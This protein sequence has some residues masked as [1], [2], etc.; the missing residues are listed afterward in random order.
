M[1][2]T[3]TKVDKRVLSE[4]SSPVSYMGAVWAT[5]T[6]GIRQVEETLG[7]Y[8]VSFR[9]GLKNTPPETPWPSTYAGIPDSWHHF[10]TRPKENGRVASSTDFRP[11]PN[12]SRTGTSE[13]EFDGQNNKGNLPAGASVDTL[14]L[15]H[16]LFWC[17]HS[18]WGRLVI[19]QPNSWYRVLVFFGEIF[20]LERSGVEMRSQSLHAAHVHG[21]SQFAQA[22]T[23][24]F[25]LSPRVSV[26]EVPRVA[27]SMRTTPQCF[28][29]TRTS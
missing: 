29:Q 23:L 24:K 27:V 22:S 7:S 8:W 5:L 12:F 6:R 28:V 4:D 2:V 13:L 19:F 1:L 14:A 25:H 15:C 3:H 17:K 16:Q 26:I 18:H 9:H 20:R 21:D 10:G 11:A